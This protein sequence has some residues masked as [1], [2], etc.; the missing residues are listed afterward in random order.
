MKNKRKKILILRPDG[1][2]DFVLFSGMIKHIKEHYNECDITIACEPTV[3]PLLKNCPYIQNKIELLKRSEFKRRYIF[4]WM[5]KLIELRKLKY[6]VA[7]YPCFTRSTGGDVFLIGV[8]SKIKIAFDGRDREKGLRGR[9][10]RNNFIEQLIVADHGK[11]WEI[12]RNIELLKKIGF[13]GKISPNPECWCSEE[14]YGEINTLSRKSGINNGNYI[15][16]SIGSGDRVRKWNDLKWVDL[17]NKILAMDKKIRC[18]FCGSSGEK[19]TIDEIIIKTDYLRRNR[20][21]N[22]AGKISL[23]KFYL[24]AKKS[25][26]FIG[27]DSGPAHLSIVAGTKAIILCGGGYFKRFFPYPN[28]ISKDRIFAYYKKMDCFHCDWKCIYEEPYCITRVSVAQVFKRVQKILLP[29]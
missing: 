23:R 26:L 29:I 9:L 1:I 20:C 16:L 21:V 8:K 12:Y 15:I 22:F 25:K 4:K 17:T 11:K 14:D 10:F 3:I 28:V 5:L 18:V 6:D 2:G 27:M 13:N 24:L 7:I 19:R